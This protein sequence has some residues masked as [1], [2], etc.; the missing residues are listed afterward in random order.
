MTTT[1]GRRNSLRVHLETPLAA[2]LTGARR[3]TARIRDLALGGA[4][5]ETDQNLAVGDSVHL[6][7]HAGLRAIQS[8]ATVRSVTPHGFGVE[9]VNMKPEDRKLLRGLITEMLD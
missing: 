6:E 1:P 7:I 3:G 8:A 4:F 9:F 2:T 5:L